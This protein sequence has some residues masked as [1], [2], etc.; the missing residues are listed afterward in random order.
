MKISIILAS[1]GKGKEPMFALR[2]LFGFVSL[3]GLCLF[4]FWWIVCYNISYKKKR[5]EKKWIMAL[6]HQG[7]LHVSFMFPTFTIVFVGGW[8]GE[9]C[10]STS[11]NGT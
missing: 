10:C 4:F 11:W 2:S 9:Q 1:R 7:H 8:S 3:L 5:V 6:G